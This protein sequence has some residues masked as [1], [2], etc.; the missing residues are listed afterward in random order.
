MPYSPFPRRPR[1]GRSVVNAGND[2]GGEGMA[3]SGFDI[4]LPLSPGQNSESI[5]DH[6][7][8]AAGPKPTNHGTWGTSLGAT[9][10]SSILSISRTW[11]SALLHSM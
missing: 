5:I 9:L 10:S 2:F 11:L 3:E 7:V 1:P 6:G 4:Y 8:E